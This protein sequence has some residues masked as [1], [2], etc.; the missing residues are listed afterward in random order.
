MCYAV[1]MEQKPTVWP[2]G[3]KHVRPPDRSWEWERRLLGDLACSGPS[4]PEGQ[5]VPMTP[6]RFLDM[7]EKGFGPPLY[8]CRI[9]DDRKPR[10]RGR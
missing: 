10:T 4:E 2:V 7:A 9:V 1:A 3:A 6:E 5:W 8:H